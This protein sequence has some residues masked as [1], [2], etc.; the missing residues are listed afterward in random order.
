MSYDQKGSSVYDKSARNGMA[1]PSCLQIA[2]LSQQVC[3]LDANKCSFCS[4]LDSKATF[5]GACRFVD[6]PPIRVA[7]SAVFGPALATIPAVARQSPV[8]ARQSEHSLRQTNKDSADG[9]DTT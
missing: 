2:Q 1:S 5:P 7:E 3:P 4:A 6:F 9:S 8:S